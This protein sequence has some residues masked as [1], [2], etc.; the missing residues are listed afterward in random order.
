MTILV[1]LNDSMNLMMTALVTIYDSEHRNDDITCN[2]LRFR[3]TFQ[4]FM[5]NVMTTLV[6]LYDLEQHN[7]NIYNSL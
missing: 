1:L 6:T 5:N 3:T 2:F 7:D 4:L